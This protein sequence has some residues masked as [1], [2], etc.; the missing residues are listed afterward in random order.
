MNLDTW[1]DAL[2]RGEQVSLPA[3]KEDLM[4]GGLPID[5][6]IKAH[7]AWR[8]NWFNALRAHD[9][10]NY[11]CEHVTADNH[12]KVGQWIYG[13]G[14]E[15]QHLVE[16]EHLR[17]THAEF[18]RCAGEAVHLHEKGYFAEAIVITKR[19]LPELS[20]KVGH[21]FADLLEAVHESSYSPSEH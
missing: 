1:I 3:P 20:S 5:E 11:S 12:C 4:L 21:C 16:Y 10:T 13:A 8:E 17:K 2:L 18:H 14:T 7:V 9:F 15:Y 6:A 19:Q